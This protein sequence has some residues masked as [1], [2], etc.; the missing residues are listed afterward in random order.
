MTICEMCG[1]YAVNEIGV[2][3]ECDHVQ[4]WEKC[5]CV[6]CREDRQIDDDR[7]KTHRQAIIDKEEGKC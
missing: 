1:K 6:Y 2:C 7:D 3:C 4:G 5:N